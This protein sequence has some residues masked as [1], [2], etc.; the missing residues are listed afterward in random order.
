M[1]IQAD[2]VCG[3]NQALRAG[4]ANFIFQEHAPMATKDRVPQL[5]PKMIEQIEKLSS[6]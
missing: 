6:N 1:Q 2:P 3:A 4:T 5:E